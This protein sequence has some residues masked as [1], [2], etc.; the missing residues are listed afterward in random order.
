MFK[1]FKVILLGLWVVLFLFMLPIMATA[2][3]L[4]DWPFR[5][6]LAVGNAPTNEAN[7]TTEKSGVIKIGPIDT[8]TLISQGKMRSDCGDIRIADDN[9]VIPNRM[10]TGCNTA[11]TYVYIKAT[12]P[13]NTSKQFWLY[14]GKTDATYNQFA[15]C[16]NEPDLCGSVIW[17]ATDFNSGWKVIQMVN[18]NHVEKN[19]S[20]GSYT[21]YCINTF[22]PFP[23]NFDPKDFYIGNTQ[24]DLYGSQ[25]DFPSKS[26]RFLAKTFWMKAGNYKFVDITG[27]HDWTTQNTAIK[28]YDTVTGEFL[29]CDD[30]VYSYTKGNIGIN[31]DAASINFSNTQDRY[32]TMLV[33]QNYSAF[34]IPPKIG[35]VLYRS[36]GT[37]FTFDDT[38]NADG[39][40]KLKAL[41]VSPQNVSLNAIQGYLPTLDSLNVP[42]TIDGAVPTAVSV[43]AS[44]ETND[45]MQY[46]WVVEGGYADPIGTASTTIRIGV[47]G[48]KTVKAKVWS[49]AQGETY[50]VYFPA[51]ATVRNP[52]YNATLSCPETANLNQEITCTLT[53]EKSNDLTY[54]Y[55]WNVSEATIVQNNGNSVILKW[56]SPGEK[57]VSATITAVG[58]ANFTRT[59]SANV[60]ATVDFTLNGINCQKNN[61]KVGESVNCQVS[62]STFYGTLKYKWTATDA[63][64]SNPN[65]SS[66]NIFFTKSGGRVLTAE[67][68]LEEQPTTKKYAYFTF[69]IDPLNASL[70]LTCPETGQRFT[71]L[72]CSATGSTDWGTPIYTWS[73]T[74]AFVTN[75]QSIENGT[76]ANVLAETAG[77]K[78]VVVRMYFT[79]NPSFYIEKTKSIQIIVPPPAIEYAE[80][81]SEVI[82]GQKVAC[83]ASATSDEG[84]VAYRWTAS[85]GGEI[86]SSTAQSTMVTFKSAGEKTVTLTA[87]LTEFPDK[88]SVRNFT[89]NVNDNTLSVALNCPEKAVTDITF[90]CSATASQTNYGTVGYRFNVTGGSS[91]QTGNSVSIKPS[92]N[93]QQISVAVTAYL[94]EAEWLTKT[95]TKIIPVTSKS[96]LTPTVSGNKVTYIGI[97]NTY[98]ATAPCLAKNECSIKFTVNDVEVE[99]STASFVFATQ[100][101][102]VIKAI[103]TMGE[104]SVETSY[105][106]FANA[107]PKVYVTIEGPTGAFVGKTETYNIKLP[108]KYKGLTIKGQWILPNGSTSDS[109]TLEFTPTAKEKTFIKYAAWVDGFKELTEAVS[110]KT[111][112]V[113]DYVFP[114]PVIHAQKTTGVAPLTLV[115]KTSF[116]EK[117]ISGAIYRIN[118]KWEIMQGDEVLDTIETDKSYIV[119]KFERTGNYTV[120]LTATDQYNNTNVD[121]VNVYAALATVEVTLKESVNNKGYRA[122]LKIYVKP[123]ISGNKSIADKM[124]THEW[125]INNNVISDTKPHYLMTTLPDPGEYTITYTATYSSGLV[126]TGSKTIT[127]NPNQLPT[128]D[129]SATANSAKTYLALKAQCT[130]PDGRMAS[131]KWDLGDGRGYVNG[132]SMMSRKITSGETIT[133]KLYACDD[134]QGCVEVTKE[135]TP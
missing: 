8:A 20:D 106:V 1:K 129:I 59:A 16:D 93:Q 38:F 56:T 60:N 75:V 46:K 48:Q 126:A 44:N 123:S 49:Q 90:T 85:T 87:Y 105:P 104:T 6:P 103:A 83:S 11:E 82:L 107:L 58:Y 52:I 81:T 70:N 114:K 53:A 84:T 26:Y 78:T 98:S 34:E 33:Y 23:E 51:T 50:A 77:E 35:Y 3:N 108:D 37:T 72:N 15:V 100:G 66:T 88:A 68:Y 101:R 92:N 54:S 24:L 134:A 102:H 116:T 99:N 17:N 130:D 96:Y 21:N 9:N 47:E 28:F 30:G 22:V 95:D 18:H 61:P 122:P 73:A 10:V 62:A 132:T 12:I 64:I 133:I 43:N 115:F 74:G 65:G 79:E 25:Y 2:T 13:A 39:T 31:N 42:S 19:G 76:S 120:K 63:T 71:M 55:N 80:C 4:S 40:V 119:Y 113:N 97:E 117:F 29:G 127:V 121:Q 131:Y 36:S 109:E 57:Q 69:T 125:K 91:Q 89:V 32:V 128:C 7:P 41:L 14:H 110:S 67:V 112:F 94:N 5:M 118:Y 45:T 135:V 86:S 111:V 27:N 124:L